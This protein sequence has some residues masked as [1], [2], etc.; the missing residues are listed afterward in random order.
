MSIA[1]PFSMGYK[2]QYTQQFSGILVDDD[3]LIP[4]TRI[5]N[6]WFLQIV[7]E[8]VS[9]HP[10]AMKLNRLDLN[11]IIECYLANWH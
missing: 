2:L 6:M 1:T 10:V 7:D 4:F 8:T 5:L 11:T 9:P 3:V